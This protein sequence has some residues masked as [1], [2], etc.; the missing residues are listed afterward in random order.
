MRRAL[1]AAAAALL[2]AVSIV[3]C[4]S[5]GGNPADSDTL[6]VGTEGT[7]SPFSYQ[8]TDGKLT[9]Y[10]IEIAQA[11]GAKLGK[12][13]EFVADPLGRDLRGPG[14]QPVRPRSRTR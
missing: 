7:Y 5:S 14:G 12:Q 8:G 3:G 4:G 11:V 13:V 1:L 6:R 10:D 2:A 9:G